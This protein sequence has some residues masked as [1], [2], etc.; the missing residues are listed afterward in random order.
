[1]SFLIGWFWH[2]ESLFAFPNGQNE[3]QVRRLARGRGD[4]TRTAF[5][6]VA[7][8]DWLSGGHLIRSTLIG[9]GPPRGSSLNSAHHGHHGVGQSEVKVRVMLVLL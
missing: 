5:L 1:M 7:G 8:S 3:R 6:T 9:R 2:A 4:V